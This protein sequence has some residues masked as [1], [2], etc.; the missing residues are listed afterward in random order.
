M[1][2]GQA[3]W[4]AEVRKGNIHD[5]AHPHVALCSSDKPDFGWNHFFYHSPYSP[6]LTHSDFHIFLQLKQW[7]ESRQFDE[8][9][10]KG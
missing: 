2:L 6:H 4:D 10:E 1:S 9:E 5:N 7:L 8:S 3:S